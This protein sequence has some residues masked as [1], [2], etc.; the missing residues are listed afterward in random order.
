MTDDAKK[1]A[2]SFAAAKEGWLKLVC[3]YPNLSGADVAVAVM[4]SHEQQTR[5]PRL[6]VNAQ[7][8]R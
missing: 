2:G 7:T 5:R 1:R 8:G 3:S 4:L 6:A